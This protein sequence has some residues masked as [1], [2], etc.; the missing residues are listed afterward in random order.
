MPKQKKFK[1]SEFHNATIDAMLDLRREDHTEASLRKSAERAVALQN[2]I[3]EYHNSIEWNPIGQRLL[4]I[5][6]KQLG[7][8][9]AAAG[10]VVLT[11]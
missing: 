3:A 1:P 2:S 5:L 11:D 10:A 9:L 4:L 8:S 7:Q 6:H